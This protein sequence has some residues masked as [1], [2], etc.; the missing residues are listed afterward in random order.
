MAKNA[1]GEKKKGRTGPG[2][3]GREGK[4]GVSY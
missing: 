3:R 2:R 4:R 1:Y